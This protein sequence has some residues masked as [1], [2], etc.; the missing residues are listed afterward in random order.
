MLARWTAAM[1]IA[2]VFA[3]APA[4]ADAVADFYRGKQIDLIIGYGPSGGYDVYARLLARHF[5]KFIPGNPSVVAQNM[6]GGGSLRAV[7]Y[8]YNLAPRD[9][10][11]I[12]TFSRNMPLI[13]LLGGNPNVQF[14]PRKLTWIGSSSS[15]VNDA[16]ILIVRKDAPVKSIEEARRPDLP[17]LVLGGNAESATGNDVPII[18]RD[19]IGLHVK[20]VVGYP[21]SSAIFLAIE[22]GEVHGRTV[23]LSSVKSMKPEWLKPDSGFRVLVQFAR[24][25]RH[26]DFPD[27]P[28]ARE[29]ARSE[30]ARALIELAELPYTLS[31][32]FAAPP[33]IPA[34]RANALQ[35]AFLA[36]HSDPHYLEDAARFRVDVSPIAG[37]EVLQ[38]IDRI[39]GAPSELLEYVRK[40][41]AETKGGG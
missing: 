39:A 26:P 4:H 28:T 32:P 35:R 2:A 14:K 24:T 27:V 6:P 11:V 15:F 34:D 9:G 5:G 3:V 41:L 37:T 13:G 19:T 8:L 18:L 23:D 10:T 17:A 1:A 21:D 36:V 33:D 22:R 29:L 25:T 7:N 38:A 16:Y 30:A 40:L 20:Q 12:G 31:R